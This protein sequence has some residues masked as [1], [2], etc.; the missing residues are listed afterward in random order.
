MSVPEIGSPSY[1][2]S[3]F[4]R[5]C[6]S[7]ASASLLVPFPIRDEVNAPELGAEHP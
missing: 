7:N 5:R 2:D 4:S 3:E 1:K 6:K